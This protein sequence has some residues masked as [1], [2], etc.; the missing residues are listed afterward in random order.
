MHIHRTYSSMKV[1]VLP[2]RVTAISYGKFPLPKVN[3]RGNSRCAL[4]VGISGSCKGS[5]DVSQSNHRRTRERERE[6]EEIEWSIKSK[7]EDVKSR[8]V[9]NGKC[10]R[11]GR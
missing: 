9:E 4:L 5:I 7:D 10:G 8:G 6:M 2:A 1:R 3:P 11:K